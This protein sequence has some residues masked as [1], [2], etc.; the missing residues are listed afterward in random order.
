MVFLKILIIS[1]TIVMIIGSMRGQNSLATY[2][3]LKESHRV[4]LK[5]VNDLESENKAIR[6]EIYKL[7][8]SP[9]YARKVL[10]DK[11]HVTDENEEIIFFAN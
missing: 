10:R 8:V 7:N 5:A 9:Q 11:Y 1:A 2:F 3:E 4:L 6:D